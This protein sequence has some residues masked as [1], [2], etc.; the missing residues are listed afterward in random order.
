MSEVFRAIHRLGGEGTTVLLVEQSV[1]RALR[2]AHCGYVLELGR[3]VLSG[4]GRTLLDNPHVR[5]AYL[6][7]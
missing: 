5:Q 6:G 3:V 7:M 2:M 4:P 1:S